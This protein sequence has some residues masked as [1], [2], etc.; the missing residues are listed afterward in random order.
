MMGRF[1][2]VDPAELEKIQARAM[3]PVLLKGTW[4]RISDEAERKMI[5]LADHQ[6]N[7]PIGVAFILLPNDGAEGRS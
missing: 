6:P 1:A 7:V 4:V 2:R 5:T 3:D